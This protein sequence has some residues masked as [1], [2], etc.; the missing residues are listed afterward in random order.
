MS[1]FRRSE[2]AP[3]P[4]Y[5]ADFY[6][7]TSREFLEASGQRIHLFVDSMDGV[8]IV[9]SVEAR[10]KSTERALK[11]LKALGGKAIQ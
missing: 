6:P 8:S 11:R 1:I 2:P 3:N 9:Q 10:K 4:N 7:T 5:P